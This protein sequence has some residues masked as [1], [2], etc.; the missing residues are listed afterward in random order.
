M[1]THP[2]IDLT[3]DDSDDSK[4]PQGE[5]PF[6]YGM[7]ASAHSPDPSCLL[8]TR[9]AIQSR[10]GTRQLSRVRKLVKKEV[11]N[12]NKTK[13][14]GN[15]WSK[16][17]SKKQRRE[18]RT[19]SLNNRFHAVALGWRPGIYKV[20]KNAIAQTKGHHKAVMAS[21][22]TLLEAEKFMYHNRECPPGVAEPLPPAPT[23][24]PEPPYE[25]V[26]PSVPMAR[27]IS[28]PQTFEEIAAA[29]PAGPIINGIRFQT[30]K[31][32]AKLIVANPENAILDP[33]ECVCDSC[34][35]SK[36][37]LATQRFV[38]LRRC[39]QIERLFKDR[40]ELYGVAGVEDDNSYD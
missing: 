39:Y 38:L 9:Q 36:G 13:F 29:T 32:L 20:R 6:A 27:Y 10:I 1:A 11:R 35:Y 40:P 8:S 18:A 26:M 33:P 16:K 23:N 7:P 2:L 12:E 34:P 25:Y 14:K 15:K 19:A 37:C 31:E 24:T 28:Q 17:G 21:F 30:I 4:Y 3:G 5:L 22:D